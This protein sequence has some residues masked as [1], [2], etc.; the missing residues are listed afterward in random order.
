MPS[1]KSKSLSLRCVPSPFPLQF[2]EFPG[3]SLKVLKPKTQSITNEFLKIV[4]PSLPYPYVT[5][6]DM[7]SDPSKLGLQTKDVCNL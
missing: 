7:A 2:C 1:S 3:F 5:V 6:S 4:Y